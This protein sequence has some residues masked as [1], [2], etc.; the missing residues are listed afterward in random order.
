MVAAG[1]ETLEILRGDE[2]LASQ[3][4]KWESGKWT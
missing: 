3:P 1:K 4:Y 2:L